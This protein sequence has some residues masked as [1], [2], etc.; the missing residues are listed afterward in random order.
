[1]NTSL[2]SI[3][4]IAVPDIFFRPRNS[5]PPCHIRGSRKR[6]GVQVGAV[7]NGISTETIKLVAGQ[8]TAMK[9]RISQIVKKGIYLPYSQDF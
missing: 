2:S 4:I 3:N 5:P 8:F 9:L 6:P 7:R 1:V